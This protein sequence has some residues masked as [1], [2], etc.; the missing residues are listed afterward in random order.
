M[1]FN[2]SSSRRAEREC[3]LGGV[4]KKDKGKDLG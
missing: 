3:P 1:S 4:T 2:M